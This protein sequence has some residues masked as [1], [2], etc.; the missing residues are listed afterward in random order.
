MEQDRYIT[1]AEI[2]APDTMKT[3]AA[4]GKGKDIHLR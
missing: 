3:K 1:V 2:T 4:S